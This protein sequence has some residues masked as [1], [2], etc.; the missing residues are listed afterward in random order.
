[1]VELTLPQAMDSRD[2]LR[3]LYLGSKLDSAML[4]ISLNPLPPF[5][6]E[7]RTIIH[8]AL[9]AGRNYSAEP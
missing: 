2:L 4:A 3:Y 8:A 5:T 6:P 7:G 1:M 9:S